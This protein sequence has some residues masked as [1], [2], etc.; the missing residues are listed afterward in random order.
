MN[1]LNSEPLSQ[2][3][4]HVVLLRVALVM[5]SVHSSKTLTKTNP[6]YGNAMKYNPPTFTLSAK[7]MRLVLSLPHR[8]KKH[9]SAKHCV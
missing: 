8:N 7:E 1:E 6:E 2:L 4:L 3:Q 5:V 9:T